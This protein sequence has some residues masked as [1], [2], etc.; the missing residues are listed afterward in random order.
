MRICIPFLSQLFASPIPCTIDNNF[1]I[2]ESPL[3][4]WYSATNSV[5]SE[6][7]EFI[8]T[9]KKSVTNLYMGQLHAV[10]IYTTYLSDVNNLSLCFLMHHDMMF[11]AVEACL[12]FYPQY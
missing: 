4:T 1:L 2:T 12:H 10:H 6:T 7:R 8:T 9:L 3:I 11:S 5:S